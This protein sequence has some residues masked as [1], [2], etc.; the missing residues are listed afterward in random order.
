MISLIVVTMPTVEKYLEYFLESIR[1]TSTIISEVITCRAD[2]PPEFEKTSNSGLL[3]KEI[4]SKYYQDRKNFDMSHDHAFALH[5]ALEFA[6]NDLILISDPD[7]FF[8][9]SFDQ[10]YYELMT[11]YDLDIIGVS[12]NNPHVYV[13]SYFPAIFNM[14]V[15]RSK[16]PK[17]FVEVE[18][19]GK[20][21]V[22]K[23]FAFS[24]KWRDEPPDFFGKP[25]YYDTG[26]LLYLWAKQNNW[27][28]LSF[29]TGDVHN[30]STQFFTSEP[31]IKNRLPKRKILYH[32]SMSWSDDAF[33]EYKT[34]YERNQ[35]DQ[36]A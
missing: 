8:H 34:N 5:H 15:R 29:M 36:S 23:F 25:G 1:K 22:D 33:D 26:C 16:L 17:E 18:I 6:K 7:I 30:Y 14:L 13:Q 21:Y 2:M 3:I 9:P 28:W 20:K 4:G 19:C 11:K 12:R 31:K 32:Q 35:N 24:L 27:R 10:F